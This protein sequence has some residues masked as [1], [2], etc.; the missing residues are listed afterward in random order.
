MSF[1]G[2]FMELEPIFASCTKIGAA[3]K[4]QS[5]KTI[6]TNEQIS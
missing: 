5:D 6:D 1:H 2:V 3:H 4:I